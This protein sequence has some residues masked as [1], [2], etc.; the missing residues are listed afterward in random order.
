MHCS[1]S[2]LKKDHSTVTK[3]AK[4][5]LLQSAVCNFPKVISKYLN[6]SGDNFEL[7]KINPNNIHL[8]LNLS[9]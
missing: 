5:D 1:V 7:L 3:D 4:N 9:V 6:A 2:D 8:L